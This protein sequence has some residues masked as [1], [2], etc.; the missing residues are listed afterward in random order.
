MTVTELI[1]AGRL[2]EA[3]EVC[4][5]EER[6]RHP[7]AHAGVCAVAGCGRPRAGRWCKTHAKRVQRHGASELVRCG[8]SRGYGSAHCRTLARE[9][10]ID[11]EARCVAHGGR[12]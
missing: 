11:V 5:A 12:A 7:A 3:A 8:W 4:W 6:A 2:R 1:A 9:P 10:R